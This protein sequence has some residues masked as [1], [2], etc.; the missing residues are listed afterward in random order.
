[1]SVAEYVER[2]IGTG[3][4]ADPRII[5]DLTLLELQTL[6]EGL[7]ERERARIQENNI[8]FGTITA[9]IYN[10]RRTKRS[11]RVWQWNDFYR[12]LSKTEES[13]DMTNDEIYL[14][15]RTIFGGGDSG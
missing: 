10:S 6:I 14:T 3:L 8:Y 13:R 7:C 1:M 5:Y 12:D 15:L 2:V 11:D 4:I 9:A